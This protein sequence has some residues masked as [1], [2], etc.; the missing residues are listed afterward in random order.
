MRATATAR[1]QIPEGA[2]LSKLEE[3]ERIR[4]WQS[5]ES[6]ADLIRS[7]FETKQVTWPSADRARK[8]LGAI[9]T[10]LESQDDP[11]TRGFGVT[12]AEADKRIAAFRSQC[13]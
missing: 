3:N 8:E 7:S 5:I 11:M 4:L 12:L 9:F 2:E 1:Q 6:K 13:R 10:P